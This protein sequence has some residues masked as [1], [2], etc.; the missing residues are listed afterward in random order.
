MLEL[1]LFIKYENDD[2]MDVIEV[3]SLEDNFDNYSDMS[4]QMAGVVKAVISL[5]ELGLIEP[6]VKE[7]YGHIYRYNEDNPNDDRDIIEQFSVEI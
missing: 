4:E 3:L 7:I 2:A 5:N 6:N 1:T